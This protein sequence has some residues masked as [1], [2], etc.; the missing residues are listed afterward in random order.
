MKGDLTLSRLEAAQVVYA[1]EAA[2]ADIWQT[3]RVSEYNLTG[4]DPTFPGDKASGPPAIPRFIH[5]AGLDE[6]YRRHAQV[7]AALK[8][9]LLKR[10]SAN[11]TD[12]ENSVQTDTPAAPGLL[13][14]MFKFKLPGSEQLWS[15]QGASTVLRE[16]HDVGCSCSYCMTF[17]ANGRGGIQLPECKAPNAWRIIWWRWKGRLHV[18][19]WTLPRTWSKEVR[20]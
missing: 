10:E 2:S 3:A 5:R 11:N 20:K 9:L 4:G 16:R 18:L 6:S 19:R 8:M 15:F 13:E 7:G 1:L 12:M 17:A 14:A